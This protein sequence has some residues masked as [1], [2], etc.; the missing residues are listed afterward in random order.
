MGRK[1]KM[2][3][4]EWLAEPH[5]TQQLWKLRG[6]LRSRQFRLF[7]CACCRRIWDKLDEPG[8]RAVEVAERFADRRAT[9]RELAEARPPLGQM[10]V[11]SPPRCACGPTAQIIRC[12]QEA[13]GF[14]LS[15]EWFGLANWREVVVQARQA[16][17]AL[18]RDIAGNPFRRP[19]L[20]PAW[21]H[22][23]DGAAVKLAEAI[24]EE[25]AFDRL[26]ILADA[27]EEAGCT[28]ADILTHCRGGGEHVRGCWVVDLLRQKL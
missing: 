8:R 20:S 28:D 5:P 7:A 10:S 3:E 22:A 16:Q 6:L 2:T 23:Q 15:G 12:A 27:L 24:Y 18:L 11:W 17:N 26:P 21:L 9:A 1:R 14:A 4:A 25:R 13:A 19:A